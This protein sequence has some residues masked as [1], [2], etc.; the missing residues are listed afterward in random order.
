[1]MRVL[2]CVAFWGRVSSVTQHNICKAE[3]DEM[4][5]SVL[6]RLQEEDCRVLPVLAGGELAG[7]L[8]TENLGEYMMIQAVL[9][10]KE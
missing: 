3:A 4:V 9:G 1:M 2:Q 8:A 6:A 10:R 7:I 5:E